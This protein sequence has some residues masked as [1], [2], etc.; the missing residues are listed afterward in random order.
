VDGR[1]EDRNVA[2]VRLLVTSGLRRSEGSSLLTFEVPARRLDGGRYYQGKVAAQVTRS[3]KARTFYVAADAVGAR[4]RVKEHLAALDMESLQDRVYRRGE[5]GREQIAEA[6]ATYYAPGSSQ[7][8]F[9]GV[10]YG[11][12]IVTSVLTRP[13]WLDLQIPLG[14]G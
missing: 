13:E 7:R 12:R 11:S 1:L 5:V 10:Q 3:K 14:Q 8:H 6:L 2:F 4:R 9:Y